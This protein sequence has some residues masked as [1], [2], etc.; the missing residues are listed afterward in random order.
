MTK[1]NL[2]Q[3]TNCDTKWKDAES[4]LW[5]NRIIEEKKYDYTDIVTIQIVKEKKLSLRHK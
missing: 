2:W 4:K 1:H 3:N 5:Q